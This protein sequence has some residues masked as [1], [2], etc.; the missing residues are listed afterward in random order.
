MIVSA[1]LKNVRIS[2]Q[3]IKPII[4]TIRGFNIEYAINL[5]NFSNKKASFLIKKLLISVLANAENNNNLNIDKL[6]ICKIYST[7]ASSF[8]RLKMRAKGRSDKIIRRNSH[9]FVYVK[10]KE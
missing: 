4:D 1:I 3:K 6:Y 8:K 9:I 10:E 5:L 7:N 2:S